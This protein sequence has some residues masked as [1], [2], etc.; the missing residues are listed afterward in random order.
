MKKILYLLIVLLTLGAC[1]EESDIVNQNTIN[2]TPVENKQKETSPIQKEIKEVSVNTDDLSN[3]GE[4]GVHDVTKFEK[5]KLIRVVDGDTIKI[6]YN[7]S[8]ESVRFLLIDT[9]ETSHPTLKE[10]PF[11]QEAKDKTLEILE[12]SEYVYI[13]WDVSY[14]DKYKR[15]L[16]YVYT[17]DGLNIQ[18]ELLKVGLTRVG[19]VYDSTK[20]LDRYYELQKEAQEK[21]LGIWSIED[22]ATDS[23][24][25][26]SVFDTKLI[27]ETKK[28]N[29]QIAKKREECIIKGNVNSKGE[30]IYHLPIQQY[31]EKT[32]PEE[33]FCTN[34]EA[35]EAGY[36]IS[37]R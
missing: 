12:G 25:D 19:Y 2:E 10:Q 9:P 6:D 32:E 33:W 8:D 30:K 28:V 18:E 16:G 23:G 35:E 7:G 31:Y 13:E 4:N 37:K 3:K 11:G 1:V 15:L 14:R 27:N 5:F 21:K 22:Y 24:F 36:R 17:E 20:H 29:K 34:E 26:T